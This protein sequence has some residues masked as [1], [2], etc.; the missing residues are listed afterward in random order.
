MFCAASM[1]LGV[2]AAHPFLVN[3]AIKK[4]NDAVEHSIRLLDVQNQNLTKDIRALDTPEGIEA[5]GRKHGY[6][7]PNERRLNIPE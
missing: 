1:W 4:D 2:N 7:F 3:A 6:A 5:M